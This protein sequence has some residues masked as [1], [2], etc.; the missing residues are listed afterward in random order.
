MGIRALLRDLRDAYRAVREVV[1]IDLAAE[2]PRLGRTFSCHRV[3]GDETTCPTCEREA[4]AIQT[5]ARA[6]LGLDASGH[7]VRSVKS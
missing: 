1:R 6:R 7:P 4:L 2:D 3:H 5:A